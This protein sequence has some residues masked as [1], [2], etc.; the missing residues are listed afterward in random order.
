MKLYSVFPSHYTGWLVHMPMGRFIILN[1]QLRITH[2]VY[3]IH[4]Q[5]YIKGSSVYV[6]K[7]GIPF[8]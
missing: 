4:Q 7:H 1:K 8:I 2:K 5:R 6:S 3:L